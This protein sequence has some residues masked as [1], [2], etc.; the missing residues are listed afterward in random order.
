MFGM[1][2]SMN[3]GIWHTAGSEWLQSMYKVGASKK[4]S[5]LWKLLKWKVV[6]EL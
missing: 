5:Y 6:L 4:P 2:N 3:A 1:L